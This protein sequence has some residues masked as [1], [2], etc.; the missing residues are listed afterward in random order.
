MKKYTERK[1]ERK[2]KFSER[3]MNE[4]EIRK[5]GREK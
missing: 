1:G 4:R 2:I 3:K 5:R